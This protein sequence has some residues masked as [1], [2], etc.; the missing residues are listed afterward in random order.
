MLFVHS[1]TWGRIYTKKAWD[2]HRPISLI[3]SVEW[4]ARNNPMAAPDRMVLV[5]MSLPS[6]PK[7]SEDILALEGGA[8]VAELRNY[9]A[10]QRLMGC[11]RPSARMQS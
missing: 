7:T 9:V 5:P 8:G 1:I 10:N 3:L 2:N 11:H 4:F 6:Y